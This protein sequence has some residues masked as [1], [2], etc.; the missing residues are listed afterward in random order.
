MS[1][2]NSSTDD[3]GFKTFVANRLSPLSEVEFEVLRSLI[4][5]F[6]YKQYFDPSAFSEQKYQSVLAELQARVGETDPALFLEAAHKHGLVLKAPTPDTSILWPLFKSLEEDKVEDGL[7]L[8][9]VHEVIHTMKQELTAFLALDEEAQKDRLSTAVNGQELAMFSL[10]LAALNTENKQQI[11]SLEALGE[12]GLS[13]FLKRRI[14]D[15]LNVDMSTPE[16]SA[17][18]EQLQQL[19]NGF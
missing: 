8:W 16:G 9:S 10:E 6:T 12:N 1:S 13:L 17:A 7:Y 15:H 11:E 14:E 2:S 18:K 19:V 3:I 5:G 4:S